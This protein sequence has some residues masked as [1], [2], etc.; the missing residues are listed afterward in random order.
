MME[1]GERRYLVRFPGQVDFVQIATVQEIAGQSGRRNT[2]I[3]DDIAAMGVPQGN[4][5]ILLGDQESDTSSRF[6]FVMVSKI[7]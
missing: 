5:D 7:S 6:R 1:P 3:L 2:I 4:A